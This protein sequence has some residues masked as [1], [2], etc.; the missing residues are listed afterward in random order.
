MIRAL[1]SKQLLEM[2]QSFFV[3]RRTG[4]LRSKV[5]SI[6]AIVGFA[7]LMVILAASFFALTSGLSVLLTTGLDW[8]YF[9]L[10]NL[11]AILLG[12][13]G[14]V[15]NTYSS[16]YQAKDNDLLLS[17]PIPVRD[18]L[19]VRLS[20]VY[21]MGLLFTALIE[22][23]TLISYFIFG[24]PSVLYA[25]GAVIHALLISVVVLTLSCILG[26]VVARVSSKIKNKSFLTVF[27]SLAFIVGYYTFYFRAST[28]ISSLITNAESIGDTIH[29]KAYVLYLIGC[30]GAGEPLPL[31]VCA[32]VI[33]GLFL[34]VCAI[35]SRSFLRLAAGSQTV[36]R[37]K[38]KA[39]IEK[40]IG[41]RRAL[42]NRELS[43]FLS[44]P[45]YML[46]CSLGTVMFLAAGVA[47]LIK[48]AVL[49]EGLL[50]VFGEQRAFI[51]LIAAGLLS[52]L[53][54]MNDITTPS[55]SL[56]GRSLWLI[57]SLPVGTA[58]VL[59]SKIE[60]HLL[61]TIPPI[62]F[63]SLCFCITLGLSLPLTLL[64]TVIACLVTVLYACFGLFLGLKM[65][66]LNWVNEA[67]AVKQSI[68]VIIAMFGG[69]A[70][71]G[72]LALV[73]YLVSPFCPAA[74]FLICAALLTLLLALL[75]LRWI[76]TRGV[77]IFESL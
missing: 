51:A 3:N 50:Q 72:V 26:W 38:G 63:C 2:N 29:S 14:S 11:L 53:A 59:L 22:I 77:K 39:K 4:K 75:L 67:V 31:L 27:L 57:R 61:M 34:L 6:L 48:G 37:V 70:F 55:V 68:S 62:L 16:L 65:P 43:R 56:E 35:L 10:M 17:L 33:L 21:L 44:S 1:L 9:L 49:R 45:T 23:P 36:A 42:F 28:M 32:V 73:Y 15:F 5:S 66:N 25:I 18:I 24:S 30:A 19:L 13:F 52:L 74:V 76:L 58:D 20:G 69:W 41:Q 47:I 40:P 12:V 8:M 64:V 7:V 54:S 71:V 46:N 60:L